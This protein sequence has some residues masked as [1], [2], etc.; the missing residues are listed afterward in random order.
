M[1]TKAEVNAAALDLAGHE[2]WDTAAND[3][4]S[5]RMDARRTIILMV[6][7]AAERGRDGAAGTT[8]IT[9]T[10]PPR[11]TIYGND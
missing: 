2:L 10:D 1:P 4:F 8:T 5:V 3:I 11:P 7:E 9:F 6:L